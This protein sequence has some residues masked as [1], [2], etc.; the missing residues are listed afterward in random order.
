MSVTGEFWS[1]SSEHLVPLP[2]APEHELSVADSFLVQEGMV[3]S[4]DAHFQRFQKSVS[5]EVTISQL[6][7][8]FAAVRELLPLAGNW[9]PRIEY[10]QGAA[11]GERLFL[12]NRSAPELTE[13]AKLWTFPDPDPRVAPKVKG[14]DLALGMQLRRTANLHGADEAVLLS[15]EGFI[16]DGALSS[17]MWWRDGVLYAPDDSTNW[18]PSVTREEAFEL[19]L[20]AGF[21]IGEERMK[22]ADLAG[23]EVWNVSSTQGIRGVIKWGEIPIAQPKLYHSFRKRLFLLF[24]PLRNAEVL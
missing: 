18:L 6:P 15:P 3:R 17:I 24:T 11:I 19:A 7:G 8:F 13:T 20:Q 2:N 23:A 12:Q 5:D 16:A 1:Y 9:F 10:R 14:P 22:P 4:L 21:E